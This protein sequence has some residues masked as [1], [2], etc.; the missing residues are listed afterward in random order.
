MRNKIVAG[1]WK[2]NLDADAAKRLYLDLLNKSIDQSDGK[3]I[4]ILPPIIY[5]QDFIEQNYSTEMV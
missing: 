4:L 3:L 2:M 5:L 1:N